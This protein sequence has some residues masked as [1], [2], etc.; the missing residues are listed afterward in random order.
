MSA[1]IATA[2]AAVQFLTA[3]PDKICR[4]SIRVCNDR[5]MSNGATQSSGKRMLGQMAI[6]ANPLAESVSVRVAK[7]LGNGTRRGFK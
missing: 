2:T 1:A 3:G 4:S 7:I 5:I 6:A